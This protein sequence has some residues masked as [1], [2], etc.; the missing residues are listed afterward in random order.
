MSKSRSLP[1]AGTKFAMAVPVTGAPRE[2]LKIRAK[3][4]SWVENFLSVE[5]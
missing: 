5:V 1:Y 3:E 4:A 2:I